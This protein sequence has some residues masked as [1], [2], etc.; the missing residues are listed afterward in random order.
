MYVPSC[1]H[2]LGTVETT[3]SLRQAA[4]RLYK[5]AF[6]RSQRGPVSE[7]VKVLDEQKYG[8]VSLRGPQTRLYRRRPLKPAD[9]RC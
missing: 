5:E 4:T 7:Q 2:L 9:C 8:H 6:Y 3:V 1:H